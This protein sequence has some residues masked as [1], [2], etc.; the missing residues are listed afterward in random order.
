MSHPLYTADYYIDKFSAI[1]ECKWTTE[2]YVNFNG[3]KCAMGHCGRTN[4]SSTT[5]SDHL[6]VLFLDNCFHIDSVND[7][8][9]ATFNQNSPKSRVLAALNYI[10]SKKE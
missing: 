7:G 10:K 8:N 4:K 9:I 6:I 5:E 3:Q 1:P 2:N